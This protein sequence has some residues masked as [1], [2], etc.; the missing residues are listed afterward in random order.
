M[1]REVYDSPGYNMQLVSVINKAFFLTSYRS[2]YN[3]VIVGENTSLL[4]SLTR[5]ISN[6]TGQH[7]IY[8]R[9]MIT[10]IIAIPASTPAKESVEKNNGFSDQEISELQKNNII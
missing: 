2:L 6:A 4:G 9:Y 5:I 10:T 8:M 3:S 7:A 1:S